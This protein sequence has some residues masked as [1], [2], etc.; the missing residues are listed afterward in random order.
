MARN[1][2]AFDDDVLIAD[3]WPGAQEGTDHIQ[4]FWKRLFIDKGRGYQTVFNE[5][6]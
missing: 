4:Y 2:S 6:F 5:S 1:A 3:N